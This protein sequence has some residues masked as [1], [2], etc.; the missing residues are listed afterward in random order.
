MGEAQLIEASVAP[1]LGGALDRRLEAKAQAL[2]GSSGTALLWNRADR[3]P[4]QSN[5]WRILKSAR[6]NGPE[7][8]THMSG[9]TGFDKPKGALRLYLQWASAQ[10]CLS[11]CRTGAYP[12]P[13]F[14]GNIEH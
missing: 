13:F 10:I 8:L 2:A 7:G 4:D 9:N 14:S 1:Q 12:A 11:T 3:R 6:S 5:G